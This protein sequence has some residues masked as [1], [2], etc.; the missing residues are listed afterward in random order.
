MI[1]HIV[2]NTKRQLALRFYS[3]AIDE[4][5]EESTEKTMGRDPMSL[6]LR[7]R[8]RLKEQLQFHR[9]QQHPYLTR[10][11]TSKYYTL[12]RNDTDDTDNNTSK[13][14]EKRKFSFPI[15]GKRHTLIYDR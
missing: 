7:I 3:H 1:Q 9:R 10:L 11:P 14:G 12:T 2:Q 15:F 6:G 8:R 4:E 13:S 5:S